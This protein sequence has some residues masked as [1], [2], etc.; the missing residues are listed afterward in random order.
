[1]QD[2]E[3]VCVCGLVGVGLLGFF[4]NKGD[5]RDRG[6]VCS[7]SSRSKRLV[8]QIRLMSFLS[9]RILLCTHGTGLPVQL[10]GNKDWALQVIIVVTGCH[11]EMG[12]DYPRKCPTFYVA[13]TALSIL[14]LF[15]CY[16][17]NSV[18]KKV[19]V[20]YNSASTGR[21]ICR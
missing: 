2:T 16:F 12:P 1:M 19:N 4:L 7:M 5:E 17:T 15:H 14:T 21:T 6:I 11:E 10:R 8:L 18:L 9:V 13:F 20:D 3:L